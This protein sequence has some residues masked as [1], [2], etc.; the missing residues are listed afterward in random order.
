MFDAFETDWLVGA[1]GFERLH[2]RIGILPRLSARGA[3]LELAHLEIKGAPDR[4]LKP[5]EAG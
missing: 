2:I 5:V 3:G 1:A 4:R